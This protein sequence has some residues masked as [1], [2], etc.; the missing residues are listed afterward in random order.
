MV[1][2][3]NEGEE[4]DNDSVA[5][6]DQIHAGK[7]HNQDDCIVAIIATTDVSVVDK[8][9][10]VLIDEIANEEDVANGSQLRSRM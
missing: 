8:N 5:G 1:D 4:Y 9:R 3:C 10:L 7:S 2:N 6:S